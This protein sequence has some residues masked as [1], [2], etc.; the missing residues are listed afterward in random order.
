MIFLH[1][2]RFNTQNDDIKVMLWAGKEGTNKGKVKATVVLFGNEVWESRFF[3]KADKAL[4]VAMT[5]CMIL[6]AELLIGSKE[7]QPTIDEMIG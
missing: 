7:V 3:N 5:H 4:T 6:Q 1:E 2:E